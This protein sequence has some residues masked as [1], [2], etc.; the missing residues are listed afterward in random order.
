M[1]SG[2]VRVVV[3]VA[4]AVLATACTSASSEPEA[5]PGTSAPTQADSTTT[6]PTPMETAMPDPAE[7]ARLDARL[8]AA[9]WA[10]DVELASRLIE[11]GADVNAQ[12]DTQQSAFLIAA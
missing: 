10:N 6:T 11:R 12:D 8:I 9:A 3:V 4:V 7:Q 1:A 2:L 5:R